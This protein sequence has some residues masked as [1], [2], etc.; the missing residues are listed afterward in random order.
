[1]T[2]KEGLAKFETAIEKVDR[3][4][5][6]RDEARE[7]VERVRKEDE[8]IIERLRKENEQMRSLLGGETLIELIQS[9]PDPPEGECRTT[10]R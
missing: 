4:R 2:S 3:L 9:E 10:D 1:M 8:Q 6:E 7:L 5:R